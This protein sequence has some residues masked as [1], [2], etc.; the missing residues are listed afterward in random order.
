MNESH[1]CICLQTTGTNVVRDAEVRL[2]IAIV[3]VLHAWTPVWIDA[4]R[5]ILI[6]TGDVIYT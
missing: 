1:H 3:V 5:A 6:F 2:A 4:I